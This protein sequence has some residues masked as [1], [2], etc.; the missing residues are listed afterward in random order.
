MEPANISDN[1][2]YDGSSVYY[3]KS[4]GDKQISLRVISE[5]ITKLHVDAIV[6]AANN[7]LLGGGGVDG[8]IHKAAGN[9]L[10]RECETLN[11]CAT[12]NAKI[13]K[14]YLLP[15]KFVI[16]TV[17]PVWHRGIRKE[18]ELL[19]S[20]Y[21]N[22]LQIAKKNKFSS[23]AFPNISTGIYG[24]PKDKAADIAINEVLKFLKS[25]SDLNEV[26]FVCFDAENYF[27]YDKKL[28][29]L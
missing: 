23:I 15:A 7:T 11:G 29:K 8:A 18:P 5:D 6:N 14:G 21:K 3:L 24:F 10:L 9:E 25:S 19:A 28:K 13:T 4:T 2:H 27:L 1:K 20:C 22:C 17:G 16:H 12:G 26:H